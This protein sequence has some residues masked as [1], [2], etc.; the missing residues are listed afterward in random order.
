MGRVSDGIGRRTTAIICALLVS[1]AMIW[2]IWSRDLWM[3]Y[4]FGVVCGFFFGGFDPAVTALIGDTFG[5][6]S[7]GMIMGI[8][9]VAFGIGAAIGPAV[10]G[11][12]FDNSQSYSM[13]F[14]SGALA[15]LIVALLVFII[16]KKTKSK[17]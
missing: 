15:M 11:F 12:V 8:L 14:L 2:L 1:G 10:G 17:F 9:N 16:E 6:R 5:L 3:L 13:A 4:L 7:I